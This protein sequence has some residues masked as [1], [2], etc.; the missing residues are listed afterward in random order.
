VS[1]DH[2]VLGV[3]A[4]GAA[5]AY[6]IVFLGYHHKL[7][8][9]VGNTPVLVTYCTMCRTG[10]V[11]D[12]VID[13]KEQTFR[14]VGAR[15]YNAILEDRETRSWWY[16]ATGVAA[17]G[18]RAGMTLSEVPCEQVTLR[19]WI[20]RY[21]QTLILQ[22]EPAF[23]AAYQELETYD[24]QPK[25]RD[26]ARWKS[27]SWVVGAD[28]DGQSKAYAWEDLRGARVI[29]DRLGE[30][31]VLLALEPDGFS[32]EPESAQLRDVETRS[33]WN[34][35]GACVEG[36]L[37]GAEMRPLPAHQDYWRAWRTFHPR[38]ERWEGKGSP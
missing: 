9:H 37:R 33:H 31:D 24:R 13:G 18:K 28:L 23:Q 34:F 16:Q 27:K 29:N 22:S 3:A 1:L 12:P 32:F 30:S 2:L 25:V 36:T 21:P 26:G 8:D 15:R 14:L 11:F 35:A 4:N 38:T 20:A 17:A 5:K 6:P 19:A 10:R 7:L